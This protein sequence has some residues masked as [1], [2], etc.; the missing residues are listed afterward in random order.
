MTDQKPIRVGKYM[1]AEPLGCAP[2]EE[3]AIRG[4]YGSILGYTEWYPK[5]RCFV[6]RPDAYMVLS[7]ECC[8]DMAAFL[9]E[10]K[11]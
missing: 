9:S 10:L 6:F 8:A 7:S 5:W 11:P 2:P 3:Y 4:W 1:T